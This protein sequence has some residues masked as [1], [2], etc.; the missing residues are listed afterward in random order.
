MKKPDLQVVIDSIPVGITVLDLEGHIQMFNKF[1]SNITD[2]K[3][4]YLGKDIRG[5]HQNPESNIKIDQIFEAIKSTHIHF[6]PTQKS[7]VWE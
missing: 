3:P 6:T 2:R 1:S 4:E 7:W 5:C